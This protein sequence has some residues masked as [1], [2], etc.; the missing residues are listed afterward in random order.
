MRGTTGDVAAICGLI[1]TEVQRGHNSSV[2]SRECG[3]LMAFRA[4]GRKPPTIV[5]SSVARTRE[6]L[7]GPEIET[8]MAAAGSSPLK[9]LRPA[10]WAAQTCLFVFSMADKGLG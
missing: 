5:N 3:I 6:Y 4:A 1:D 7:T 2:R 9:R 10:G 8:L